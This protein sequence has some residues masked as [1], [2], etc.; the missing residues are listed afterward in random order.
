MIIKLQRKYRFTI[1]LH[2]EFANKTCPWIEFDINMLLPENNTD[3]K[4]KLQWELVKI[5]NSMYE[6]NQTKND[7]TRY[8]SG[9]CLSTTIGSYFSKTIWDSLK[10]YSN[11][12]GMII[13][14]WA[15]YIE[16]WEI[17]LDRWKKENNIEWVL[18]PLVSE[19]C[20]TI[21]AAWYRGVISRKTSRELLIDWLDGI[22]YGKYTKKFTG[23]HATTIYFDEK[24]GKIVEVN[25]KFWLFEINKTIY[26][27]DM[28]S[29]IESWVVKPNVIFYVKY[30]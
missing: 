17:T 2:N 7:C 21:L 23:S 13:G 5:N 24:I 26:H 1:H 25:S 18:V 20:K 12:R 30:K 8:S 9:A 19:D 11:K 4:T 14:E 22:F 27:N 15:N 10:K 16:Q 3:L 6:Y 28:K 29:L